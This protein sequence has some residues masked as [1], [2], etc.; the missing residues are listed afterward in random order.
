MQ[1]IPR[2]RVRRLR[3]LCLRYGLF[4]LVDRN[5]YRSA[6]R[7]PF[8]NTSCV[9]VPIGK[10]TMP[11]IPVVIV[12][13]CDDIFTLSFSN[14]PDYIPSSPLYPFFDLLPPNQPFIQCCYSSV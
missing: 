13:S 1:R 2:L 3:V 12:S 11:D 4:I 6:Y 8:E 14:P 9:Q 10:I 7:I 5:P